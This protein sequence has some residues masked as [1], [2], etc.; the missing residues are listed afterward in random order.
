MVN[1]STILTLGVVG[2]VVAAGVA[3][4]AAREQIGGALSRGITE[5]FTD[6][7]RDYFGNLF[8]GS[9][10][11]GGGTSGD[12]EAQR[13]AAL[14]NLEAEN[15]AARAAAQA[16]YEKQYGQT[17]KT[18]EDTLA[19]YKKLLEGQQDTSGSEG[20]AAPT[21]PG[22]LPETFPGEEHRGANP[23][24]PKNEPL[25]TPSPAG[26]YYVDYAGSKHD[27]QWQL[28]VGQADK[29][30]KSVKGVGAFQSLTFLGLS[31]LQPAGFSVFGKS[32]NYL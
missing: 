25:F 19:I 3:M 4:Y 14:A 11:G 29:Y 20:G 9:T 30:R 32:Q 6:P 17:V 13:Q 28:D 26:Y 15:A 7:F 12:T 1:V 16:S 2:A 31:K 22:A 8:R 5:S 27:T 24:A 18:Y 23:A 10:N 21:P